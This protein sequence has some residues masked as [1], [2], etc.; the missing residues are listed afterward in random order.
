[1][2]QLT[3]DTEWTRYNSCS[4]KDCKLLTLLLK[5]DIPNNLQS[6]EEHELYLVHS[7]STVNCN[8]HGT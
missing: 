1:M 6:L 5:S 2:L 7:V 4:S 3:V 8:M